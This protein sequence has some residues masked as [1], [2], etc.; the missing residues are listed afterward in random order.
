MFQP[1][2]V[3]L[4]SLGMNLGLGSA[5][6]P[7]LEQFQFETQMFAPLM[8]Y[9]I[10]FREVPTSTCTVN[11][12]SGMRGGVFQVL[13]K[14]PEAASSSGMVTPHAVQPA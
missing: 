2:G 1:P 12:R 5:W 7:F 6:I 14:T 4:L 13:W 11:Y 3:K 9:F 8:L 10:D